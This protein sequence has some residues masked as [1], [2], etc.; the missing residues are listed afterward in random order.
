MGAVLVDLDAVMAIPANRI[1]QAV[2]VN[3]ALI[4][5]KGRLGAFFYD[6]ISLDF[7]PSN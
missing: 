4:I 2:V 5:K 3:N 6:V 1:H 7:S